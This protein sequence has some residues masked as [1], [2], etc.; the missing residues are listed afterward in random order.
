MNVLSKANSVAA[1]AAGTISI[2]GAV[3]AGIIIVL[4]TKEM[5]SRENYS[6]FV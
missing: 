3:V 4:Y 2:I 5:R 6:D 1:V